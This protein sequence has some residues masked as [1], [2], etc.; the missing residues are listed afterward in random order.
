MSWGPHQ[1]EIYAVQVHLPRKMRGRV[2]FLGVWP[3]DFTPVPVQ[4]LVYGIT[5]GGTRSPPL[6]RTSSR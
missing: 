2:S 4:V 6:K 1:F 3:G 5:I